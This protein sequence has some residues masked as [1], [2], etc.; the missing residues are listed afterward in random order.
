MKS[1]CSRPTFQRCVLPPSSG[2][3]TSTRLHDAI[4]H[5]EGSNLHT[6]RRENLKS[7]IIFHFPELYYVTHFISVAYL[8]CNKELNKDGELLSRT[9]ITKTHFK[10]LL[11]HI[12]PAET[13]ENGSTMLKATFPPPFR[14]SPVSDRR[15]RIRCFWKCYNFAPSMLFAKKMKQ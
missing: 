1:L 7:H 3:S 6:R 15:F 13:E 11:S 12:F 2:R 5:P 9:V 14:P 10:L 4:S 8:G